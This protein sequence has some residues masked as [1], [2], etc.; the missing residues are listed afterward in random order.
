MVANVTYLGSLA[1][2]MILV[3]VGTLLGFGHGDIDGGADG[4][5]DH[6]GH[7]DVGAGLSILSVAGIGSLLVGFGAAGY[8]VSF[9]GA[10]PVLALPAGVVGAGVVFRITAWVRRMLLRNL[11]TGRVSS[12]QDFVF[13]PATVTV[14]IPAAGTGRGQVLVHKGGRPFYVQARTAADGELPLGANVVIT[15]VSDGVYLVEEYQA[16]L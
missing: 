3:L 2:G 13:Q 14:P 8:T 6:D 4:D 15:A 11:E 1:L 12:E 10:G 9:L 5:L 7:G 16:T